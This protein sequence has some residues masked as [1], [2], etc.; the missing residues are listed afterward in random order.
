M[1]KLLFVLCVFSLTGCAQKEVPKTV[2][3]VPKNPVV[4]QPYQPPVTQVPAEPPKSDITE[5]PKQET[6]EEFQSDKDSTI[7]KIGWFTG[8]GYSWISPCKYQ[9]CMRRIMDGLTYDQCEQQKVIVSMLYLSC[10]GRIDEL[11]GDSAPYS[12]GGNEIRELSFAKDIL[13]NIDDALT[14][15]EAIAQ[16]KQWIT[17]DLNQYVPPSSVKIIAL[18]RAEETCDYCDNVYK[19]KNAAL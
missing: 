19:M 14:A 16:G 3:I 8:K 9:D 1:R 11:R 7:D 5:Q 6:D 4:Q 15:Q 12:S 18:K 13:S 2:A 10:E 17:N